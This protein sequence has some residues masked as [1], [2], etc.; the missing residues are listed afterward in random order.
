MHLEFHWCIWNSLMHLEFTDASGNWNYLEFTDACI[1]NSLMHLEFTD[2]SGI[3]RCI[4][5]SPMHLEFTDVSMVALPLTSSM[6]VSRF[7]RFLVVGFCVRR[8][9][10]SWLYRG[11]EQWLPVRVLFPCVDQRSGTRYHARWDHQTFLM[12]VFER[13]LKLNCSRKAA[14]VICAPLR[15]SSINC[16]PTCKFTNN[17]NNNNN[18]NVSGIH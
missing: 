9:I 14:S 17:N 6:T 8:R 13:N 16:A 7:R 10:W 5:N 12:T 11:L 4:W 18:N 2:A 3:H 15:C 1:W